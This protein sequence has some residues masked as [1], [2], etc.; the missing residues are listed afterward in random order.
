MSK[1]SR[2][3]SSHEKSK[4]ISHHS[5]SKASSNRY[6]QALNLP[7]ICNINARSVYNKIEELHTF[8]NEEEIDLLFLSETWERENLTLKQVINLEQH[9][10]FSSVNQRK[11]GG[12]RTAIVANIDKFHVQNIT[13]T[14]VQVPWGVEATWC[15]VTPKT[16]SQDSRIQKIACCSLYSVPG[17]KK[18]SLLLDHLSDA[19]HILSKRY[20]KGLFFILAGD[21]N[22]FDI[23]SILNLS[24]NFQQIVKDYTRL[25]PPALLDPIITTLHSFYQRPECIAPL[26]ADRDKDGVASDHKIV[27][28][29]PINEIN[30]KS[31][32]IYRTVKVRP[33]P[34]S[35]IKKI[36]KWFIDQSWD[37][38]YEAEDA[39]EKAKN[40]QN[41]LIAAL[42]RFFPEKER[43]F[44][45]DDKPWITHKIK[46]LD[47]KRK[48]IYHL[49]RKSSKWRK[50]NEEFKAEV[51]LAK[52]SFYRKSISDLKSKNPGQWYSALKRITSRD[53]LNPEII[54]DEIS[55]LSDQQQAEAIADQFSSIPNQ[56][57][58]LNKEDVKIPEFNKSEIPQFSPAQVWLKLAQIQTNKAT[59]IG[60]FQPKLTKLFAAYIAEPLTDVINT[61]IRDGQ[62]P[63][64]YKKEICTPVP[65]LYPPTK[66]SNLRNIS[67]LLC[68]DKI[69]EKL[70]SELMVSDMHAQMDPKQYGNERGMSIQHYLIELIHRI[71]TVL[72]NN[73]R[74]ETFAII[75]NLIDWNNAFPRQDPK[76]GIEAFIKCG[77]RPALI[78]VLISY[79]QDR[80]MQVK[81]HN[82]LSSV[83]KLK[84][85]GPQGATIGL[86]E[87]IAQSNSCADCVDVANRF[88]FLDDLSILEILN[89]INIGIS[90][91][92]LKSHVPSNIPDHNQYIA[93]ESLKSQKWLDEISK[94]TEDQKMMINESKCKTMIFN[95]TNNYKFTTNLKINNKSL[96][97]IDST[98]LLGTILSNDLKWDLNC[99]N[100][101]KK[102]NARMQLLRTISNFGAT[103][104]ELKTVYIVFIR[105]L[106]EQSAT[107][108]HSSLTEE[109]RSDLERVQKTAL[110]II[111]DTKYKSYNQA[112]RTLEIE[113]LETRRQEL[114]LNFAKKATK[115]PRFQ[116]LFPKNNKT[117][118]MKT[119][120]PKKFQVTRAFTERL[121]RSPI[122][123]MQTL[124]NES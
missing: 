69:A 91:Y 25:D 84:G 88:R 78:P 110:K 53:Q 62:Y 122:I 8:I 102:A 18:K 64:I 17:S 59:V 12:G 93:P 27:V 10:V 28:A 55:H 4:I 37:T 46:I 26:D 115:H 74:K 13:N 76:L 119:R 100:I 22:D 57:Q 47:R 108:W 104:E 21:T 85:G 41:I 33:I 29:K 123:Y 65:K 99:A 58:S 114:C 16:V 32:R 94:W 48:R 79:F 42:E 38:V 11:G 45:S 72:D 30:N 77:V 82:C 19:F 120:N 14:L 7:T 49:E 103:L 35:G 117:H 67:G 111:L 3:R 101:I 70:I 63:E 98:K 34:K 60:D 95:F 61:S 89:L 124:L 54:V 1:S 81:W 118:T 96:E 113:S 107:V 6:F 106:L 40:L 56:Y 43:K 112:L 2:D 9:E 75:V 20:E 83:R 105:S 116:H 50:L 44:A 5:Q 23:S 80:E 52:K 68:F 15:I 39:N 36:E 92:N 31:N 24:P 73:S 86:L 87:Y 97:V 121:K 66:I 90:S 71:V 109:N 51:K